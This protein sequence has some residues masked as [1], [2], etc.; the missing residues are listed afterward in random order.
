MSSTLLKMNADILVEVAAN[1]ENVL[2][3]KKQNETE[4]QKK[5]REEQER[6]LKNQILYL[7]AAIRKANNE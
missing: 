6:A 5:K 1:Y 4:E 2:E 7:L 3:E